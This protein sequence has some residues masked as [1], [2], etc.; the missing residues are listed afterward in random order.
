MK[1]AR[2][3]PPPT[4]TDPNRPLAKDRGRNALLAVVGGGLIGRRHVEIVRK[5][6]ELAAIVDPDPEIRTYAAMI[7]A[8]W[9]PDLDALLGAGQVDGVIVA[10]PNRMHVEQGLACVA[11]G[12]PVLV[13]KPIADDVASATRLVEAAEAAGVPLLVGHHRRYNPLIG[14]AREA[15]RSGEIGT[16]LAVQAMCWLYKPDD[17][18]DVAWRRQKGAGPVL[19]NLIHD[20]DLLRFLCGPVTSVRALMSNAVRGNP[21]EETAGILL[22][23]AS[24]AIG[25]VTVSDAVPA[26]W[27]C[28]LTA[29]EN[30]AYPRTGEACYLIGGTKGSLSL[31]DLRQWHYQGR[32]SWWEPIDRRTLVAD[33]G[34]PLVARD[35]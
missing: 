31:P 11:A 13:E 2:T 9:F 8:A 34:D 18:F 26:P 14:R 21:V 17:Y 23:F 33:A 6:A 35:C 15:I 30:P 12:V 5:E 1:R 25:T 27:S 20:I 22:G 3:S 10:T 16:V 7:G 24:G 19:V 4:A 28:E 29:G 32:K